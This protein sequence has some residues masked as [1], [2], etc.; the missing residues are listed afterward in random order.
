M[1][2]GTKNPLNIID[3]NGL[4]IL[5]HFF[6]HFFPFILVLEVFISACIHQR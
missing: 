2:L 1:K 4:C 5:N 3:I 6:A